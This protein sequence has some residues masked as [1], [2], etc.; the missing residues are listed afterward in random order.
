MVG[1]RLHL[2]TQVDQLEEINCEL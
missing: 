2:D 1:A